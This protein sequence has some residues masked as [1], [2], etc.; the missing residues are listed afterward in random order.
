M[1]KEERAT[2]R[3]EAAERHAAEAAAAKAEFEAAV[4]DAVIAALEPLVQRVSA[5]EVA[6]DGA[7]AA[8]R[9]L[10][11][12]R[13]PAP[14][15]APRVNHWGTAVRQL[16]KERGLEPTAWIPRG[17]IERRMAELAGG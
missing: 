14:R 11:A 16:R 8:Y 17:D 15:R 12:Q 9:E 1:T 3:A 7:R 6:L 10:K 13:E 4:R 5:L 2:A